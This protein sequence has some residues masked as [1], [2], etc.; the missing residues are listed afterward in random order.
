MTMEY[1]V[2]GVIAVLLLIYLLYSM[3]RPERF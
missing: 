1:A 3:I 2:S